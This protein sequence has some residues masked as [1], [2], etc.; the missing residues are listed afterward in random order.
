MTFLKGVA[1]MRFRDWTALPDGLACGALNR[2]SDVPGLSVGHHTI[3]EDEPRFLR[4]GVSVL[5]IEGVHERPVAAAS[6]LF[7]GYGKTLGLPQIDEIGNMESHVYL[8]NTLSVGAVQQGAVS[9][10][11]EGRPDVR[12]FNAVVME[13]NDGRLSDIASLAI[14]PE[15]AGLA[16]EDARA[17]FEM[18][19]IGAGTGMICFGF[20]GGIGSASRKVTIGDSEYTVGVLVLSN[21]GSGADLRLPGC[22]HDFTHGPGESGDGSLIMIAGTDAPLM[23]HQLKRVARHMSG[24]IGLLGSPGSHGSGDFALAF[25]TG[26]RLGAGGPLRNET[27]LVN[28]GAAMSQFFRA[29]TWATAEAIVDSMFISPGMKGFR[30]EV[31]SLRVRLPVS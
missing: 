18:G 13:C 2:I 30:T 29:A 6:H 16:L 9:L 28:D 19:S 11:L 26:L 17:D 8:T 24:A 21:F 1:L 5:R 22:H 10:A 3:V 4:T 31:S 23:P 27:L 20:K 12:S 15:M 14:T 25:S 7:N